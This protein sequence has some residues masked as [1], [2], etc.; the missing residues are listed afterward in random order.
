MLLL[1]RAPR[2]VGLRSADTKP[3][4]KTLEQDSAEITGARDA[5]AERVGFARKSPA[6]KSVES[7]F[8]RKGMVRS[9]RR[10]RV[11]RFPGQRGHLPVKNRMIELRVCRLL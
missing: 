6:A 4:T 5:S 2:L 1:H 10:N 9:P 7:N 3:E 11:P 8:R